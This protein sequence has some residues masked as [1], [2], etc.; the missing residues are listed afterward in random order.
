M[1]FYHLPC[2]IELWN[3]FLFTV[4]ILY[5]SQS[6]PLPRDSSSFVLSLKPRF[7]SSITLNVFLINDMYDTQS[8]ISG[9]PHSMTTRKRDIGHVTRLISKATS[10]IHE[11]VCNADRFQIP[12]TVFLH[13]RSHLFPMTVLGRYLMKTSFMLHVLELK[14]WV[15]Y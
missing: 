9:H 5:L 13:H 15:S 4:I 1:L 2:H 3:F 10:I 8:Q 6:F 11:I 14:R 12:V 7:R